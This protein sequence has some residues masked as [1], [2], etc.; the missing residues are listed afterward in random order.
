MGTADMPD[1][2]NSPITLVSLGYTVHVK[3]LHDGPCDIVFD[4]T[5][6]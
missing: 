5:A 4:D 3:G 1:I 6:M 2:S